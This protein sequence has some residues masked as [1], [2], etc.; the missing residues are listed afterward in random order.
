MNRII[1]RAVLFTLA[2]W[3]FAAFAC[4]CGKPPTLHNR[5]N[6]N[7]YVLTVVFTEVA[8]FDK[9]N[10][11]YKFEVTEHIK[12][13]RPGNEFITNKS[14][15]MCGAQF[16]IGREYLL[17]LNGTENKIALCSSALEIGRRIPESTLQ[18]IR[19]YRDGKRPDLHPPWAFTDDRGLCTLH[20]FFQPVKNSRIGYDRISFLYRYAYDSS[21]KKLNNPQ[22]LPG[23]VGTHLEMEYYAGNKSANFAFVTGE[24]TFSASWVQSSSGRGGRY[25]IDG[26]ETKNLIKALHR[27]KELSYTGAIGSYKIRGDVQ[28]TYLGDSL[29]RFTECLALPDSD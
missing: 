18:R 8:P 26:K 6:N 28:M 27:S 12:G 3:P 23:Y 13:E 16:F 2:T 7:A 9:D 20:A 22:A 10:M 14:T 29:E 4:S 24:R 21:Q 1:F 17:L 5:Y 19:D 25:E 11:R 15:S